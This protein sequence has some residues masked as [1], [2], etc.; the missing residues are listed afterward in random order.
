MIDLPECLKGLCSHES[1]LRW[2]GNRAQA[3]VRRDRER[4]LAGCDA[5]NYRLQIHEAVVAGGSHDYYTGLPLDWSLICTFNNKQ[6]Q[7]GGSV[8][9]RR[10]AN[11][12]TVDH[13]FETD[14][15]QFRFVICS[16]RVNDAKTHLTEQEFCELCTQVL[17]HRARKKTR[18]VSA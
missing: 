13:E 12:P 18:G 8:Y 10:F 2:L 5:A 16:W 17:E 3:H 4:H 11:M 6:A 7:E 15:K 9:L 1:Y 14:G